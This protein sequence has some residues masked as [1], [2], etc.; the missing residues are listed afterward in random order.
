MTAFSCKTETLV[1]TAAFFPQ[2][3]AERKNKDETKTVERRMQKLMKQQPG[4]VQVATCL[5]AAVSSVVTASALKTVNSVLYVLQVCHW[6][7]KFQ[8][9]FSILPTKR[10]SSPPPALLDQSHSYSYPNRF[11]VDVVGK[12]TDT[13]VVCICRRVLHHHLARK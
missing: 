1:D 6:K 7:Q 2:Q 8:R 4:T 9:L 10:P 13:I 11:I 12:P 3:G 5:M